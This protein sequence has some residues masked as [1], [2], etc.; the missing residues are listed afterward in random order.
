MYDQQALQVLI[1]YITKSANRIATPFNHGKY[2][3]SSSKRIS[4]HYNKH[5]KIANECLKYFLKSKLKIKS[6]KKSLRKIMWSQSSGLYN[7]TYHHIA[8]NVN[9]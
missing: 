9:S 1:G 3:K 6:K 8:I 2:S 7:F 5:S 4:E